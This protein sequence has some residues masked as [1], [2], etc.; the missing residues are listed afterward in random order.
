MEKT[1]PSL[2]KIIVVMF[3]PP[4]MWGTG[5][6]ITRSLLIE[7]VNEIFLVTSRIILVS[8]L[9][10]SYCLI[11]QREKFNAK[12]I[13]EAS[14]TGFVSIFI[15]GWSL[16]FALQHISS[17]LVTLIISSAPMFV[18]IW[19]KLFLKEEEVS[20]IRYVAIFIGFMGLAYLFISKETGLLNQGNIYKGGSLAFIGVQAIALSTVL[21]RKFAPNYNTITWLAY[22]YPV[23]L[24]LSISA[25]LISGV[26]VS[27]L[28]SSQ[29]IRLGLMVVFN[30]GAFLSFTWLI[31]R[32][33]ALLVSTVDYMVPIV[34]VTGGVILLNESFNKNIVIAGLFI[35]ISMILNTR[36][37]FSD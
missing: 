28:D 31:Q 6:V 13:R 3:C 15:V 26:G 24:L 34:G 30:L 32:V 17:G 36:E 8:I 27:S 20:I 23:T 22:Q 35:F 4:L 18:I 29:K 21:N 33:S 5:N 14:L 11:F 16:I 10:G 19:I 25:Y 1:Q 9:I 12:L 7:G 2:L 37:E